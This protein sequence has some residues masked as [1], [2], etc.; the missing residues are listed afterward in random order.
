MALSLSVSRVA[1]QTGEPVDEV[2][3]EMARPGGD[4]DPFQPAKEEDA[5]DLADRG[6][7]QRIRL[8][9]LVLAGTLL[10]PTRPRALL[11]TGS[12]EAFLVS[13]GTEVGREGH[14]VREIAAGR[15]LLAT[16]PSA[17]SGESVVEWRLP[18][19]APAGLAVEEP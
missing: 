14:V 12:G 9:E 1:A 16:S 11:R 5:A 3:R 13:P 10:H 18:P 19:P 2:P 17:P 15:V 8:A 6:P 7:L 4:R